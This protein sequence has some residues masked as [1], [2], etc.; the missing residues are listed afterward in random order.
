M[1]AASP[2]STPRTSLGGTRGSTQP[3]RIVFFSEGTSDETTVWPT[4]QEI[5]GRPPGTFA[6]WAR[7]NAWRFAA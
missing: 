2:S 3:I 6:D 4:V 5:L 1:I 7:D